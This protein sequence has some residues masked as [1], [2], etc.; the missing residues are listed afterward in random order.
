[1]DHR[2]PGCTSKLPLLAQLLGEGRFGYPNVPLEIGAAYADLVDQRIHD[3]AGNSSAFESDTCAPWCRAKQST[4]RL[5]RRA[6]LRTLW[7][8]SVAH[9][10]RP[11][12]AF[13]G[14][15]PGPLGGW[16]QRLL[17]DGLAHDRFR[18]RLYL[19]LL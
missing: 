11:L 4:E 13:Y 18:L 14:G 7:Q 15:R 19:L 6:L 16:P 2:L 9:H 12:L 3:L 1:A 10:K 5:D 8:R 17:G